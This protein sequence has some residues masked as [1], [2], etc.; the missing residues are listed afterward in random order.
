MDFNRMSNDD[1]ARV[2]REY[3]RHQEHL[4]IERKHASNS[5][6]MLAGFLIILGGIAAAWLPNDLGQWVGGVCLG[7]AILLVIVSKIGSSISSFS[8]HHHNPLDH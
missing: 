3:Q 7:S 2:L 4:E 6:A 1:L 8:D 5:A